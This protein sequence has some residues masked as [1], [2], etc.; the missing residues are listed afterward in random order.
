M[1]P[2][3]DDMACELLSAAAAMPWA[4]V[5]M[6]QGMGADRH[7][8]ARLSG[9]GD[10][11]VARVELSGNG[12]TWTPGGATQRLLIGVRDADGE[13]IDVAALASHCRDE[14]ALRTGDGW[15]LG[16]DMLAQAEQA[17][18]EAQAAASPAKPPR[19]VRLR[20]FADPFDWMGAGGA[21]LCVLD[22]GLPALTALR[23]LGER[24]TL[25]V[26]AGAQERLRQLLAHG[27]LPRVE[28]AHQARG[29]AA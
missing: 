29:L 3:A 23:A 1:R 9:A 25:T 13:L 4:A 28:A 27:G 19:A 10:L 11:G 12:A 15:A 16:L 20:L 22:W 6:L 5:Q 2:G 26:E 7:L 17:R 24:V 18:D 14:W 21:G 8:I